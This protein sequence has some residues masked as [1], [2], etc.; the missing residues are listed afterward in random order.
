[1]RELSRNFKTLLLFIFL[2]LIFKLPVFSTLTGPL[3]IEFHG[4]D[5]FSN[6]LVFTRLNLAECDC[7]IELWKYNYLKDT[8]TYERNWWDK[9]EYMYQKDSVLKKNEFEK[10][11]KVDTI[12]FS[13]DKFYQLKWLPEERRYHQVLMDTT[14]YF[15]YQ[16]VYKGKEYEFARWHEKKNPPIRF[17][18]IDSLNTEFLILS[19]S[20][21]FETRDS[22]IIEGI[23]NSKSDPE[24]DNNN[25]AVYIAIGVAIYGGIIA[26]RRRKRKK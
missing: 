6:S 5:S 19:Y 23:G 18:K 9:Y 14:S 21:Q 15:P 13:L 12:G 1:M 7:P 10:L 26:Q 24:E 8:L 2:T 11:T 22:L 4:I 3:K 17:Y 25:V 16:I 20:T